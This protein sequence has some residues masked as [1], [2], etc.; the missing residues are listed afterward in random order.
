MHPREMAILHDAH[1][2]QQSRD[3]LFLRLDALT[4]MCDARLFLDAL[5]DVATAHARYTPLTAADRALWG[6][7]AICLQLHLEGGA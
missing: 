6:S 1:D 4:D 7:L 3:R 2:L 5:A